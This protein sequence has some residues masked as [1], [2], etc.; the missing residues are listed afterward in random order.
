M[1]NIL[2]HTSYFLEMMRSKDR[3]E[4]LCPGSQK[5]EKYAWNEFP[6]RWMFSVTKK[7]ILTYVCFKP[8]L[9][10]SDSILRR[11][12]T[13][14]GWIDL[15]YSEDLGLG[16]SF[17]I[18]RNVAHLSTVEATAILSPCLV[19]HLPGITFKSGIFAVPS[20]VTRLSDVNT[21]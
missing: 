8:P 4:R 17:A 21:G 9:E 11:E 10:Q 12:H 1:G 6:Q 15:S 18:G 3:S 7:A 13:Y 20:D 14:K 19:D 2:C 16:Q 5:C